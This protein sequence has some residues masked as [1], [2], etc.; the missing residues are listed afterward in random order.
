MWLPSFIL[1]CVF[2]N[3]PSGEDR[4]VNGLQE[5]ISIE[6]HLVETIATPD[7]HVILLVK[8]C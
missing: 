6:P 7:E 5:G 1:K 4:C 3:F 2:F 8:S